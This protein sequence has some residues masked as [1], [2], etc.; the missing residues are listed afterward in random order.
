MSIFYCTSCA[1]LRDSDE[2][3]EEIRGELLCQRCADEIGE[4][5]EEVRTEYKA[6]L[7]AEA[8]KHGVIL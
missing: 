4:E 2:G 1:Q 3:C 7:R 8:L 6:A 5:R